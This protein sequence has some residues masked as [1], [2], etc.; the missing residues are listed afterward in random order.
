MADVERGCTIL[1]GVGAYTGQP[2]SILYVVVQRGELT[3]VKNIVYGADP[4]AFVVVSDVHE[5]LG[6]GFAAP[7]PDK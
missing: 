4:K 1:P 7:T 2:R 6:E 3:T 5:V